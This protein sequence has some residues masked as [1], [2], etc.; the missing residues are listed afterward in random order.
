MRNGYTGDVQIP[1]GG[2]HYTLRFDYAAISEL[3]SSHDEGVIKSLF[4][5]P[6]P[7]Q[8]A[9]I[10]VIGLK[11]HHPEIKI[12]EILDHSPPLYPSINKIDLALTYAYFGPEEF[13]KA[14]EKLE[15]APGEEPAKKKKM[16]WL[17][18]SFLRPNPA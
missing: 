9:E 18:R 7:N 2:K 13:K 16:N 15:L 14:A 6:D 5:D 12:E 3:R 1:I 17:K 10:I 11:R 8:V 4:A